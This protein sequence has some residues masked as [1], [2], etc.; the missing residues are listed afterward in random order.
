MSPA[1]HNFTSMISILEE[2][3]K[4]SQGIYYLLP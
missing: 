1:A 4:K 3:N 2:N